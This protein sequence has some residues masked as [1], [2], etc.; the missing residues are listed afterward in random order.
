MRPFAYARPDTVDEAIQALDEGCRPLAGGTDLL[1]LM[2]R[3]LV[4]PDRLVSLKRIPD[5][6]GVVRL[7]GGWRIG[8]RTSLA[9]LADRC[10][11]ALRR[12]LGPLFSAA[13]QSASPQLRSAATIGGN[14]L[15]RPRCWYFR[16]P[17]IRCWRKGGDRCFAAS[18]RN[19]Y[20]AILGRGPCYA[21]HPSDPAVA[22]MALDAV[23]Q[24]AGPD[25]RRR[26][27][28]EDVFTRP[29]HD[30]R[31]E[32]TLGLRE[33]ITGL[34]VP[35]PARDAVSSY[36]KVAERAAWDFAL[37]SAAVHIAFEGE[38]V[39]EA[40]IVLGGVAS[41][42]WRAKQ[43]EM[44]LVGEALDDRQIDVATAVCTADAAPLS[45][46]AYKIDLVSGVVREALRRAN[47]DMRSTQ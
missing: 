22:L 15:Q 42:P 29:Q 45:D 33:L 46:N 39:S 36:V 41:V 9:E 25:G 32:T 11:A 43:A 2:K 16:N 1:S 14:L 12:E 28:I 20:H 8:A 38:T 17:L 44:A 37:A 30:H 4:V 34:Y 19:A 27:P 21:V 47:R 23:V 35:T 3:R 18:G 40:S 6:R 7:D 24:I 10:P 31:T 26:A 5:L 13:S